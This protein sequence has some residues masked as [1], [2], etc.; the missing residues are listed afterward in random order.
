M[1]SIVRNSLA[2]IAG[3]ILGSI[4]NMVIISISGSIIPPPKGAEI[5]T[6]EGLKASMHLFQ[7]VHFL[8][9]FL[10]HSIGTFVGA[11]AAALIAASRKTI[12]AL[13]IGIFFLI[14]GIASVLM[15][16]SPLWFTIIDLVFGYI[17]IAWIASLLIKKKPI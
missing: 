15:L 2:I 12:L 7:P 6:T 9:P 1:N 5:T 10:A 8:M 16:P 3:I 11:L 14:G 17:P 4:V 13:V